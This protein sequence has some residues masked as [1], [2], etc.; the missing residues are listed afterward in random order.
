MGGESL[1][2]HQGALMSDRRS[3][4]KSQPNMCLKTDIPFPTADIAALFSRRL[5]RA[6]RWHRIRWRAQQEATS[7]RALF[8]SLALLIAATMAGQS[9]PRCSGGFKLLNAMSGQELTLPVVPVTGAVRYR[10]QIA[11]RWSIIDQNRFLIQGTIVDQTF[12]PQT[13]I[14]ETL[15][16]TRGDSSD[17]LYIVAS[18]EVLHEDG[19]RFFCSQDF[20]VEIQ[21]DPSLGRNATR[22]VVPVAGTVH[23]AFNSFFRTRI[24]LGNRWSGAISGRIVFHRAGTPGTASDP[25]IKYNLDTHSFIAFDDIV[26]AMHLDGVG[27]LDIVPDVSVPGGYL[28]PQVRADLISVPAAGGEFSAAIPVVTSTSGY[29]GAF[30]GSPRFFIEPSHNKR[31]SVSIRSLADPVDIEAFLLTPDRT[32]RAHT[33]RSY[34]ADT[35]DQSPLSSWFNDM[36]QPGD[37]IEFIIRPSS[38]FS[39]TAG[40]I[41]FFS[42]TDNTTNDVTIVAPAIPQ[43]LNQPVVVCAFGS[44][45]SVLTHY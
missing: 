2:L 44:G 18:A 13:P 33:T 14:R 24:L 25:A 37:S 10:V 15:Y 42:E 27:S 17:E 36:Q 9:I 5:L 4:R 43:S 3:S 34:T 45:C 40:A 11:S 28:L 1:P 39:W 19:S 12:S 32:E 31:I 30:I 16:T 21:P 8:V 23:G 29:D 20:L 26:G 38:A 41:I 6:S 35:Y 22:L 7:M